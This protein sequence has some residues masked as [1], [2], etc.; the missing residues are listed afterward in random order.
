MVDAAG[1]S[2][3]STGTDSRGHMAM[4]EIG[5]SKQLFFYDYL[6]E[7]L[8]RATPGQPPDYAQVSAVGG[9]A[10]GVDEG[11]VA[12]PGAITVPAAQSCMNPRASIPKLNHFS[13][14]QEILRN[15]LGPGIPALR[16]P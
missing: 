3:R 6:I 11:C 14:A 10:C 1:T 16:Q 5:T 4:L 13:S 15:V 12:F 9:P 7:S 8:T 2:R